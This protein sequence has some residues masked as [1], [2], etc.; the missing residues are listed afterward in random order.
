MKLIS[1]THPLNCKP[2]FEDVRSLLVEAIFFYLFFLQ[3]F[4][5]IHVEVLKKP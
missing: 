1:F 3:E 5:D 4:I 2:V